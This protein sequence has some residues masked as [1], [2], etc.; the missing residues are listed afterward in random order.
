MPVMHW[1]CKMIYPGYYESFK[2]I[3][4][5]CKHSCCMGWEID[6]DK[7]SL[8]KYKKITGA[9][10]ER[11]NKSIDGKNACF[12]LE[13][14]ERC[15]FLNRQNLCEVIINLGDDFLCDICADHPRFR[16]YIGEN[17]EIGLGLCCEQA[18]KII[19]NFKEKVSLKG[20]YHIANQR[21]QAFFNLQNEIFKILQDR[22][23]NIAERFCCLE[24]KLNIPLEIGNNSEIS[25]LLKGL[26]RFD[27]AW[28]GYIEKLGEEKAFYDEK[29]QIPLE[30][31]AVYFVY[32]HFAGALEDGRYA[33]RIR[34]AVFGVYT[35]ARMFE[36][37]GMDEL[38]ETARRFSCE[39]EY[40]EQNTAA[41]LDYLS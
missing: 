5:L 27:K 38:E 35:V 13:Q 28:D 32:R 24:N 39:I 29:W 2:C 23:L 10:G 15:P 22:S 1:V 36:G 18:A 33:E 30:Q 8:E 17:E 12:V 34:F 9:F 31:L 26:E 14:N 37:S 4:S 21:E 25:K 3:A 16:N 6:I 19:L 11:L 20:D 7:E 40:S 41:I